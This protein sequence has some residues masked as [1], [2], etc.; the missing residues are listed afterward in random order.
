MARLRATVST[1]GVS[2]PR[3][4]SKEPTRFQMR[5]KRLLRQVLG[6]ARVAHDAQDHCIREAPAALVKIGHG[7]GLVGFQTA[8]QIGVVAA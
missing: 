3:S 5:R 8:H 4:A 6:H 2:A 7:F 1:H